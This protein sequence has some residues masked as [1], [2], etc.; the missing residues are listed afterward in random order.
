MMDKPTPAEIVNA[1]RAFL[2]EKAMPELGGHTAYHARVAANALA[3]A[4]REIETGAQATREELERLR[5]LLGQDGSLEAL[6]RTLCRRIR[7]GEMTPAAQGLADHL[8]R[9]T[10]AKVAIDQPSYSGLKD[11][12][13]RWP[14]A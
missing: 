4:G 11:A 13:K 7:A 10:M 1:A 12:R 6:N 2:E 9:T 5:V 3:I 14:A 8:V